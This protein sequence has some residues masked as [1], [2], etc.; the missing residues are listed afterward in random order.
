MF[1]FQ[2]GS[3]IRNNSQHQETAESAQSP[4]PVSREGDKP[5]LAGHW[6]HLSKL[7]V[8]LVLGGPH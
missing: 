7:I 5:R 6:C 8:F 3:D 1:D 4:V 2:I